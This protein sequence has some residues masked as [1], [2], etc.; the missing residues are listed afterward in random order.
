[1]SEEGMWDKIRKELATP[2][3]WVAAGVGAAGGLGATIAVG[4]LDA[5][6][7]AGIGALAAVSAR[8]AGAAALRGRNLARRAHGLI[9]ILKMRFP[10]SKTPQRANPRPDFQL[11]EDIERDLQLWEQ[12]VISH[13]QFD[14]LMNQHTDT[15]RR[16]PK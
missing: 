6:T 14:E 4:G 9:L 13:D 7:S 5:G 1:M 15:F 8:K 12:G 2:W 16:L 3:D 11:L 10:V